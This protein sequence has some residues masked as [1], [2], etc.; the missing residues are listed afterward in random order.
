VKTGEFTIWVD[1]HA[2]G[3]REPSLEGV[4]R[5]LQDWLEGLDAAAIIAE[6]TREGV[7]SYHVY[8]TL[9]WTDESGWRI[10]F[11]AVPIPNR[12]GR[13]I[14]IEGPSEPH[15]VDHRNPI[16]RALAEKESKYGRLDHPLVIATFDEGEDPA[17][18]PVWDEPLF[19]RSTSAT[20]RIDDGYWRRGTG[21]HDRV[22]AVI[23]V[24]QLL[25]TEVA[26]RAP[27]AWR[28][29]KHP[30]AFTLRLPWETREVTTQG[31]IRV[32]EPTVSPAAFF[33]LDEDW[34]HGPPV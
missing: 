2:V 8:P 33:G 23:G 22:A 18:P 16:L 29:P 17:Q 3:D 25:P 11:R 24:W 26:R 27:A 6:Y 21:A 7:G 20:Q 5:K 9:S 28:S 31:S 4:K 12:G 32:S 14:G 30:D 10:T 19:G 1:R 13:A 34:P 15:I